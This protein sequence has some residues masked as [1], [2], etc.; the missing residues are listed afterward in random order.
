MLSYKTP[1]NGRPR[2]L[3]IPRVA[4]IKATAEPIFAFGSSSRIM[5]MLTGISA[6]EKPWRPGR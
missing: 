5:L 4:L 3:P 2:A 6:E 1:A